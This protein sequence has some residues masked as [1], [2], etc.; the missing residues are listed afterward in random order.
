M[1]SWNLNI[2]GGNSNIVYFHPDPWGRFQFWR[3]YFSTGLVQPPTRKCFAFR[4]SFNTPIII[5]EYD[6]MA[7]AVVFFFPRAPSASPLCCSLTNPSWSSLSNRHTE[8]NILSVQNPMT[9]FVMTIPD[10]QWGWYIYPLICH[11]NYSNVGKYTIHGWYGYSFLARN[12]WMPG[13]QRPVVKFK[14]VFF[15]G[16]KIALMFVGGDV[17][18]HSSLVLSGL[19]SATNIWFW[20]LHS[21]KLTDHPWK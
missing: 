2:G 15:V 12:C 3:A 18:L 11:K 20:N 19:I 16:P 6:W 5:W 1:V 9:M 7:R 8:K 21:L 17:S 10:T 13:L 14:H 4:R